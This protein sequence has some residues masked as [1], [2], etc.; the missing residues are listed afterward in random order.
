MHQRFREEKTL[1][2]VSATSELFIQDIQEEIKASSSSHDRPI[3]N[4]IAKLKMTE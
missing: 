3:E 1:F 2:E 4:E